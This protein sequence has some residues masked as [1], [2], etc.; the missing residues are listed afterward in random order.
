MSEE[1]QPVRGMNDVLPEAI[2]A[3]QHFE[4]GTRELLTDYG[5]QEIRVP[6]VERT[7]LFQ[8]AIGEHTDVVGKEM[9]TF[10]DRGGASWVIHCACSTAR[11]PT[12]RS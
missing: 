2:G 7:E 6:L 5:Y 12:C 8:R 3:W 1:I 10:I 11:T 9:Y 4:S